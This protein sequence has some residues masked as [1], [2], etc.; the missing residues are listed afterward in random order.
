MRK[1]IFKNKSTLLAMCGTLGVIATAVS[2]VKATP[3]AIEIIGRLEYENK[4][5]LSKREIVVKTVP[6]YITSILIGIS[7]I[8]CII[9]TDIINKNQQKCITSAYFLV[10]NAYKDYKNKVREIYGEE[11]HQ[12]ILQEIAVEKSKDVNITA[13][14]WIENTSLDF[15][16]ADEEEKLFYDYFSKRYFKSTLSKVLQAEYHLNRNFI[17]GGSIC[18]NEFYNFLGL[19]ELPCGENMGWGFS[20][21]IDW[22]DFNH[23]YSKLEDGMECYI[24]DMP[25]EPEYFEQE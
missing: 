16:N 12:K 2:A 6:V 15:K 8:A 10:E 9:G 4:E 25:F 17:L 11:A 7:T 19:E 22:I 24:I 21:G 23:K 3:K 18:V 5:R 13:S 1:F 20:Y 14:S